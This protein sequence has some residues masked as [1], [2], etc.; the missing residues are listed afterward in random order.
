MSEV[1]LQFGGHRLEATDA[2]KAGIIAY[3]YFLGNREPALS[4]LTMLSHAVR[5]Y[6]DQ[7]SL[8]APMRRNLIQEGFISHGD[9]VP[10]KRRL[11]LPGIVAVSLVVPEL[12]H[13]K[14]AGEYLQEPFV[15]MRVL[16]KWYAS[17]RPDA[18]AETRL[19]WVRD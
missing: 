9:Q 10:I 15:G 16:E 18:R 5:R 17:L 2:E 12:E 8:S 7:H 3:K 1:R 13:G 4:P 19:S 14:V 6:D 11:R